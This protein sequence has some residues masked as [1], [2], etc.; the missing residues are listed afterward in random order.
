MAVAPVQSGDGYFLGGIS[1]T[2]SGT[3]AASDLY[4][5]KL[6][7]TL[8]FNTTDYQYQKPLSVG[9]GNDLPEATSVYA[10]RQSGFYMLGNEKSFNDNQN[11][12]LT[13][14]TSDG[15]IAWSHPIVFGGEGIDTIGA[16][17]ELPDG[18]LLILGTMRTGKP[19]AGEFKMTL[20][21][22]NAD[23]KF[24]N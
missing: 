23:G 22:V 11:W 21:K 12:L 5:V 13:K 8:A 16:I 24:E 10:S 4:A 2:K 17:E 19:D 15:T 20:M 3:T 7:K 1:Y 18:R 14:L 6:R 9:L